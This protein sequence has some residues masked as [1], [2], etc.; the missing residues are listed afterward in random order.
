[1]NERISEQVTIG[2]TEARNNFSELLKR[3][4]KGREHL[5]VEKGGIPVAAVISMHEYE[6]FR[7]WKAQEELRALMLK[8]GKKADE[9]G[10]D[11]EKLI[12]LLDAERKAAYQSTHKK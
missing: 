7:R 3:V 8:M 5:V 10:L 4:H 6:A 2:A 11:E 12:A 1:M 9:M